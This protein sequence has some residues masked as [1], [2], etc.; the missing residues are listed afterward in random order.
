[1][2]ELENVS[3]CMCVCACVRVRVWNGWPLKELEKSWEHVINRIDKF[4]KHTKH[5]QWEKEREG[6]VLPESFAGQVNRTLEV[7]A[8]RRLMDLILSSSHRL[9]EFNPFLKRPETKNEA[10]DGCSHSGHYEDHD[11]DE[12]NH[13][14]E[15]GYN[16]D[17]NHDDENN[18][19]VKIMIWQKALKMRR[20]GMR[21]I[22]PLFRRRM[23]TDKWRSTEHKEQWR[24]VGWRSWG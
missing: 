2:Y 9:R 19:N 11:D 22:Y 12:Y 1:M 16:D 17:N 5:T 4:A 24:R 14:D 10:D 13:I 23:W 18:H 15:R 7:M 8:I 21:P 3:V 6:E 20:G